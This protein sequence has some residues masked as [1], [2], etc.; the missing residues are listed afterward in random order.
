MF[1]SLFAVATL[2][3]RTGDLEHAG[4]DPPVFIGP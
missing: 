2:A 1:L 3:H 4:D